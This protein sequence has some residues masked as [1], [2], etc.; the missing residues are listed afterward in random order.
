MTVPVLGCPSLEESYR[1][2]LTSHPPGAK[3][4]E[5]KGGRGGAPAREISFVSLGSYGPEVLYSALAVGG[6][7]FLKQAGRFPTYMLYFHWVLIRYRPTYSCFLFV[8]G[9]AGLC[10]C[11]VVPEMLVST[12]VL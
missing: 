5:V 12:S 4:G 10:R 1:H 2:W 7:S 9:M 11:M 3:Q 6:S 8:S